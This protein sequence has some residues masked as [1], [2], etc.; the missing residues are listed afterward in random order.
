[1]I[2][3]AGLALSAILLL[4]GCA[5]HWAK[6]GASRVERDA[7]LAR[8]DH[9]SHGRFP[10]ILQT[11]M[12]S[13]GYFVPP[14]TRCWTANNQTQCNTSGGYWV[15]PA[16]STIDHNQD[17]RRAARLDCMY[18]AGWILAKDE[19]EAEAVTKSGQIPPPLDPSSPAKPRPNP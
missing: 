11:I 16:Y 4:G 6:P 1:M 2:R 17:A 7:A 14:R 12:I 8:C 3:R 19:K 9:E 18:S 10:P 5:E 15:P 13:P